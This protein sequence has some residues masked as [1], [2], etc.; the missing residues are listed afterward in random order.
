IWYE[1]EPDHLKTLGIPLVSGR[2]FTSQDTA[3]S[4]KVA[5]V[6]QEFASKFFPGENPIG[7]FFADDYIGHPTQIVGVV[8]HVKQWG[9]DDNQA[10][11]A[12]FYLPF[13]Q[14]PDK[15]MAR[16]HN[17]TTVL[18]RVSGDPLKM[19][20]PV[21][22]QIQEVSSELIMFSPMSMDDIVYNQS[23]LSERFSMALLSVFAIVALALAT[24]GIYGVLSYI[25]GQRSREIGIR[26][27]LGARPLQVL[28]PVLSEG[29]QMAAIGVVIG[30]GAAF[31]MTRLM[32]S[33]LYG[34]SPTDP[35]T[36]AAVAALL[37][38][39]ALLACY[40]PAHRAM[41]TD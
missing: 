41:R 16:A 14:I 26:V 13:Q 22:R 9:L 11:H 36:F 29:L 1:V 2:F 19:V 37:F 3:T 25:V 23:L 32:A 33:F 6:D 40:I 35:L 8:G 27:P 5:V 39:V 30:L 21:R 17:S 34:T 12:E 38:F 20:D 7:K 10:T 4:P 31:A 18:L 15:Y 28:R 24:V